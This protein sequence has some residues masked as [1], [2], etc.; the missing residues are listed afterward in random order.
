MKGFFKR[1]LFI[2]LKSQKTQILTIE[3]EIL[4]TYLG[5]KGLASYLLK[6]YQ[7]SGIDPL[8]PDNPLIIGLG[9][10]TDTAIYGS[11]RYGLYTKS[12]LTGFFCESYSGG[13]VPEKISRTGFD[14][15]V[16][17]GQA[18]SLVYLEITDSDVKFHNASDLKGMDCIE[19]ERLLNERHGK[20]AGTIV[21]GPAG[22]SLIPFAIVSNDFWRCAGRAGAGTVMGSKKVKA[23]VFRGSAKRE[24]ADEMA[25]KEFAKE[26]FQRC[27]DLP[28]TNAYKNKGTPMMVDLLNNANAFPTRYWHKGFFEGYK[29]INADAMQT[30]MDVKPHACAKCFMACGKLSTVKE[31]E[32]KGLTIE[33][34]EYETIYAFGGLCMIDDI[35]KIAYIND[36]CDRLG[37]DT[38]TTGNL[39]AL[40]MEASD[41]GKIKES[42]RYGSFED[43]VNLINDIAN[44]RGI[45]EILSKGIKEASRMLNMDK[46]AIHVKGL[47]PAGYDPRR[48]KGMSLAYATS[49]R[50]AC[51]LRSTFY[52][53]ELSGM[54]APEVI[55]GKA[56]LFIDFE[57]RLTLMDCLILCRFYRDFYQW[58]ELSRIIHMTTGMTLS[59]EDL[60]TIANNVSTN[61]RDYNISEGL[62]QADERIPERLFNEPLEGVESIRRDEFDKLLK[63]YYALKGWT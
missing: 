30:R 41:T 42:Y 49:V 47:E 9:P 62:T 51:H 55:E 26:T 43:A 53:A 13:K 27:K 8:S 3:D 5:G 19:T 57:D 11:S 33:G 56:Q 1:Y 61:I 15:I 21:I 6:R 14:A 59:K 63:D 10:I 35:T 24:V 46:E 20:D 29:N 32:F 25:V 12:P 60:K 16:I 36:L 37:M 7:P 18:E 4:K 50:G 39:V 31:G 54:I 28:T 34:P 38:I 45:G 17:V 48:L 58:D 2:D 23:I 40:A 22:E 52:K 44:R